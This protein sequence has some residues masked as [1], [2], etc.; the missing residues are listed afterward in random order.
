M[1]QEVGTSSLVSGL[2]SASQKPS[3]R[4]RDYDNRKRSAAAK[5]TVKIPQKVNGLS[6]ARVMGLVG[7]K[8]RCNR[9][10]FSVVA[11]DILLAFN[12]AFWSL[13]KCQQD[14]VARH[15]TI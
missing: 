11:T 9:K 14:L 13:G 3:I 15:T 10:C 6:K 12:E 4:K 7:G 8:C 5:T 1:V 2:S